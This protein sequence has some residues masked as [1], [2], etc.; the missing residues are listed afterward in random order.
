MVTRNSDSTCAANLK[1]IDDAWNGMKSL[2]DIFA[3][4]YK[5][6]IMGLNQSNQNFKIYICC[7]D[8]LYKAV[9]QVTFVYI[10]AT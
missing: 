3:C 8:D 6:F 9:V 1:E 2:R 4:K 7:M 5:F 10:V